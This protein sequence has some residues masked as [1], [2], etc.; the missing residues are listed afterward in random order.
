MELA[1]RR[2]T[3]E[4]CA[5]SIDPYGYAP[6][7][8]PPARQAAQPCEPAMV[9]KAEHSC[10]ATQVPSCARPPE[11][12]AAAHAQ[13]PRHRARQ[14]R[15]DAKPPDPTQSERCR[16]NLSPA[17]SYA[18]H[19]AGCCCPAARS[20]CPHCKK[21]H[22]HTRVDASATC[23]DRRSASRSRS[24]GRFGFWMHRGRHGLQKQILARGLEPKSLPFVSVCCPNRN[25]F[26]KPQTTV[27]MTQS[28]VTTSHI[29]TSQAKEKRTQ[30]RMIGNITQ[31]H[32][33]TSDI[34][35]AEHQTSCVR[36]L[37]VSRK[38]MLK[39]RTS[40]ITH[41]QRRSSWAEFFSRMLKSRT[42][43][44][45]LHISPHQTSFTSHHVTH[46]TA[47]SDLFLTRF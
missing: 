27:Q 16:P 42:S 6:L 45:T 7:S 24:R 4:T 36:T 44:I 41:P 38:K 33:T 32:L 10:S 31:S 2:C 25:R 3:F 34:R 46:I 1:L 30:R 23:S 5:D 15:T 21:Q 47:V 20:A 37:C 9:S 22:A 28:H 40:H 18:P 43:D 35:R 17:A 11:R 29:H 14:T 12:H 19:G 13:A 8:A 39:S 26:A